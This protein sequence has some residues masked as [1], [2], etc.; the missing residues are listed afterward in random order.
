MNDNDHDR[1]YSTITTTTMFSS[2]SQ[3]AMAFYPAAVTSAANGANSVDKDA[4]TD[5]LKRPKNRT[6]NHLINED[7]PFP[8]MSPTP[9]RLSSRLL[10]AI[11]HNPSVLASFVAQLDWLD[12]YPLLCSCKGLYDIFRDLPLRDV[13]L[14]R[15]IQGYGFCLRHRDMLL[16]QDVPITAYDLDLLRTV[17]FFLVVIILIYFLVISQCAPLNSYPTHAL[18]VLSVFYP[19]IEDDLITAKLVA[20][21]QAHSR[22]VL[23]FQSLVHS[24]LNSIPIDPPEDLSLFNKARSKFSPVRE[25]TFPAPLAYVTQ[26]PPQP[27]PKDRPLPPTPSQRRSSFSLLA[28]PPI[29][30]RIRSMHK[31]SRSHPASLS[32]PP[33]ANRLQ[34]K[35]PY[36]YTSVGMTNLLATHQQIESTNS[37]TTI[38]EPQQVNECLP[39]RRL[40]LWVKNQT[41][42]PPPPPEEPKA[43][44]MY[45]NNWRRSTSIRVKPPQGRHGHGHSL[46]MSDTYTGTIF[47][48]RLADESDYGEL[49]RPRRHF[50]YEHHRRSHSNNSGIDYNN[51]SESSISAVSRSSWNNN[52]GN[53]PGTDSPSGSLASN[54]SS[55]PLS[56]LGRYA[57]HQQIGFLGGGYAYPNGNGINITNTIYTSPPPFI[58]GG[59]RT[60]PPPSSTTSSI[61]DLLL[62]TSRNRAPIL[63]V[64]IPTHHLSP[65]SIEACERQL[66]ESG[67]WEHLSTGDVV[68]NFG[69]I[70]GEGAEERDGDKDE[71][72]EGRGGGG[73]VRRAS[74]VYP[75]PISYNNTA[76]A[77]SSPNPNN[78]NNNSNNSN[79]FERK[80]WLIFDGHTL[81]PYTPPDLLPLSEPLHL[82]TPFYYHHIMPAFSNPQFIISRLPPVL[83]SGKS[84]S[85]SS[86]TSPTHQQHAFPSFDPPF[87]PA[88]IPL[89]STPTPTLTLL[90]TTSQMPSPHSP[91]GLALVHRYAWTA[92][93]VRT[94]LPD[95]GE[96]GEGWFGEWIIECEGTKE[97]RRMLMDALKGKM[98]GK[99]VCEVV[100]ERSGG[101]RLWFRCV[102]CFLFWSGGVVVVVFGWV[103]VT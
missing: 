59:Y 33:P 96:V 32:E 16:Y 4:M 62:A 50:A 89:A 8:L 98:M 19:S 13:V 1:L 55:P 39:I 30:G 64:Y 72:R 92:R 76:A 73:V 25:L 6:I 74:L 99:R 71:D 41:S 20:L 51:S 65:P 80:K 57:N 95:E 9:R 63:R 85:P 60:P 23:L 14:S 97:G 17:L 86:P 12:L 44:K 29:N 38:D 42:P 24:S 7:P 94:R 28:G 103:L 91:S 2:P 37:T 78:N 75:L 79:E 66:Q 82:P 83:R 46:S 70:P 27:A 47:D 87:S 90:P 36:S 52:N 68:C 26:P 31:H 5:R 21:T 56:T 54:N 43:L 100:R 84:S 58:V 49:E 40:S 81:V 77:P 11:L 67:L 35:R 102:F 101:G 22:F 18:R 10:L 34:H 53:R 45:S 15:F 88:I 61:H 48:S 3:A 69:F 93:V